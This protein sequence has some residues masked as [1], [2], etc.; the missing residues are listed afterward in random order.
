MIPDLPRAAQRHDRAMAQRSNSAYRIGI[1]RSSS[2]QLYSVSRVNAAG[3]KAKV[4]T[5]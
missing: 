5:S 2:S 1:E 4:K 3:I